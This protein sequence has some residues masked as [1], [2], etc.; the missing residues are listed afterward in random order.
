MKNMDI[1][2]IDMIIKNIKELIFYVWLPL[3]SYLLLLEHVF[4]DVAKE[5]EN[6]AKNGE[7]IGN[8]KIEHQL[9]LRKKLNKIIKKFKNSIMSFKGKEKLKQD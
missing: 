8:K 9:I 6:A 4:Q 1:M 2:E 3:V 7:K 5:E